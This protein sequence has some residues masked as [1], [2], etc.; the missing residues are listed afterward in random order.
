MLQYGALFLSVCDYLI[1][2]PTALAD[3]LLEKGLR[4]VA[5]TSGHA[6]YISA[7]A[8]WGGEDI[9]KM[10][11][12][13]TLKVRHSDGQRDVHKAVLGGLECFAKNDLR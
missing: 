7:G 12:L 8:L 9:K 1:G 10:A 2:S 11:D 4:D 3:R 6:I 13:D 5:S